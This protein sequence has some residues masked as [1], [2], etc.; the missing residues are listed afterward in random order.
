M[1]S[2]N[3]SVEQ[4]SKEYLMKINKV[5]FPIMKS[6]L[7]KSYNEVFVEKLEINWLTVRK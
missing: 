6:D 4:M 3:E 7:G 2:L 5:S 1:R